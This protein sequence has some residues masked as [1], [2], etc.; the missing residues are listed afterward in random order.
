[1]GRLSHAWNVNQNRIL[2]G[3]TEA[4]R[5]CWLDGCDRELNAAQRKYCSP[6]HADAARSRRRRETKDAKHL[7][8]VAPRSLG[9]QL[10]ADDAGRHKRS[11]RRKTYA[12][13]PML[14]AATG[15]REMWHSDPER[16]FDRVRSSEGRLPDEQYQWH[17]LAPKWSGVTLSVTARKALE[18]VVCRQCQRFAVDC[19][20]LTQHQAVTIRILAIDDRTADNPLNRSSSDDLAVAC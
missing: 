12:I 20:T 16:V 5:L 9:E 1:M 19:A 2:R 7:A 6:H 14:R 4:R 17:Y 13:T 8:P 18:G 15:G 10:I 3:T 11:R